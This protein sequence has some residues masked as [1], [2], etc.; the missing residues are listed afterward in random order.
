MSYEITTK[1]SIKI[2]VTDEKT[3]KIL[4]E[5]IEQFRCLNRGEGIY[6]GELAFVRLTVN[7]QS[8]TEKED[9]ERKFGEK[10]VFTDDSDIMLLLNKSDITDFEMLLE[11]CATLTCADYGYSFL[12]HLCNMSDKSALANLEYKVL[13]Y[14]DYDTDYTACILRC[15]NS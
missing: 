11:Y 4:D 3:R 13:K 2:K 14:Y 7:G 1:E 6:S 9:W 5:L 12:S 10:P 8:V 15:L